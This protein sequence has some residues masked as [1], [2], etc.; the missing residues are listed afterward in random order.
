MK[1]F[2]PPQTLSIE[3]IGEL[4]FIESKTTNKEGVKL[5]GPSYWYKVISGID[6]GKVYPFVRTQIEFYAIQER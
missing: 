2:E 4:T 3:G 1:T 6:K 5:S